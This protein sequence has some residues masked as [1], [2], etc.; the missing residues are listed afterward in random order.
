[1][2]LEGFEPDVPFYGVVLTMYARMK[3]LKEV[4]QHYEELKK[5]NLTPN[6]IIF[7]TLFTACQQKGCF[8]EAKV[9]F[10]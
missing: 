8:E 3:K 5:L 7:T 9:T 1:M 4:K 10:F 2:K 6:I